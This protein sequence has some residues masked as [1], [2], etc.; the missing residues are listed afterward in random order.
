MQGNVHLY[1]L[2]HG[3][4][5]GEPPGPLKEFLF[6]NAANIEELRED[7]DHEDIYHQC[8]IPWELDYLSL[9]LL[10]T[11]CFIIQRTVTISLITKESS[12]FLKSKLFY[13]L[14]VCF[15]ENLNILQYLRILTTSR[16]YYDYH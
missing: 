13:Y 9:L 6:E 15:L 16:S 7:Q 5:F 4:H 1:F 3:R 10:I 11:C 14:D 8:E 12:G 2:I